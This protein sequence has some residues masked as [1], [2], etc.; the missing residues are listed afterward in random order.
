MIFLNR[1]N[2][3]KQTFQI[4]YKATTT[5]GLIDGIYLILAN[6]AYEALLDFDSYMGTR[7]NLKWINHREFIKEEVKK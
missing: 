1:T 7:K 6:S 4:K 5:E 3:M 2:N